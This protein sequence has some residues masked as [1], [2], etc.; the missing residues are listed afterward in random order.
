MEGDDSS[1]QSDELGEIDTCYKVPREF[2]ASELLNVSHEHM[3]EADGPKLK[4]NLHL[5][6]SSTLVISPHS[7]NLDTIKT[8]FLP[9]H[10]VHTSNSDSRH[11]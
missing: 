7:D 6:T 2:E 5:K 3:T 1:E 8:S 9:S 10:R 11:T 4:S